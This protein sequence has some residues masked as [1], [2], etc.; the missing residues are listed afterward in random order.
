MWGLLISC[1]T[2]EMTHS[3]F[4]EIYY[5]QADKILRNHGFW[6]QNSHYVKQN[7]TEFFILYKNTKRTLFFGFTFVFCHSFMKNLDGEYPNKIILPEVSPFIFI[8]TEFKNMMETEN[9]M[10][11]YEYNYEKINEN[12][13]TRNVPIDFENMSEKEASEYIIPILKIAVNHGMKFLKELKPEF[14][15]YQL[16]EFGTKLW[17]ENNW[18]SDIEKHIAYKKRFANN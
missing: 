14:T 13:G 16:K 9:G 15:L 2:I 3:E 10:N 7:D 18:I 8:P 6:R 1:Q 17:I 12:I 11:N 5:Y 4:N